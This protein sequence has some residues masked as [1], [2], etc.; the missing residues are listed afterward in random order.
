MTISIFGAT[1]KTGSIFTKL[2]LEKGYSVKVL[3]RTPEKL[4][5]LKDKVEVVTGNALEY[6]NV[7]ECVK[8]CDA[9]VSLIGHTR[10][11]P[12]NIQTVAIENII[13]AMNES[14]VKR[15]ISQTGHG[16]FTSEDKPT[17]IDKFLNVSINIVDPS[18]LKDGAEHMKLIEQSDLDW[19]IV[20]VPVLM[21]IKPGHNVKVGQVGDSN[22]SKFM[23]YGDVAEFELSIL[24]NPE[25]FKKSPAI[26]KGR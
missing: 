2:A 19:T 3:V 14:G 20:R 18:R 21:N 16:A 17:F 24:D 26:G 10:N 23:S 15:L 8:G 11:S 9:V 22:I 5:D 1:G 6:S 25:Y 4:G 7:L 13:K 12:E